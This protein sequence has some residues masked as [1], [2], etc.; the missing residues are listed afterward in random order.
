MCV[1]V[2]GLVKPKT[3]D[4]KD[5]NLSLFGSDVEREVKSQSSSL[6]LVS[7]VAKAAVRGWFYGFN[8]P[9]L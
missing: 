2:A 8:A 3:Y 4:W 5:S 9:K 1:C 7:A 6:L